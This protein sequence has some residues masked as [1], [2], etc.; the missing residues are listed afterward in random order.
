M[1]TPLREGTFDNLQL[2]AGVFVIGLD[3]SEYADA[4]A[5]I[6]ALA[7]YIGDDTKCLGA[8]RGGGSFN[9]KRDKRE[10]EA[11]GKRYAFVGSSKTDSVDAYISTKLIEM[12]AGNLSRGLG[13][14]EAV[15]NGKVTAISAYTQ[16]KK[17]DYIEKLCWVGETADGVMCILL[18]NALN[19]ADFA[20]KFNEKGE[21]ELD[22][23]FHA[24]QSHVN[25]FDVAPFAIYLINSDTAAWMN[26]FSV[27]GSSNGKT[28]ITV[29][30]QKTSAQSYKYIVS[31]TAIAMPDTDDVLTTGWTA[32]DGSAEITAESG[33]YIT[34]ATVTTADNKCVS[35]GSTIVRAK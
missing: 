13:S 35:A 6:E 9:V 5:L 34:V 11:D 22:V 28:M 26:V 24:H 31:D 17:S 14:A 2:D 19:T 7:E 10:V 3:P 25:D 4:P 15:K 29:T 20:Y 16:Y 30:P 12:T 1:I 27:E 18:R 21:G 23:E 8:T 32:W 33:K